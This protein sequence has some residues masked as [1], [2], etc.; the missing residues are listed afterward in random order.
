M[1]AR[2]MLRELPELTA[3]AVTR[4]G[5]PTIYDAKIDDGSS[6]GLHGGLVRARRARMR[7]RPPE[8]PLQEAME[9][10]L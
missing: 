5:L 7:R 4:L 9:V 10:M 8:L 2:S 6:G 1:R 3:Q